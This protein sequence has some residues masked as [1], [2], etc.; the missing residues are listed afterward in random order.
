MQSV[1]KLDIERFMGK[2]YVIS[3]IP[4]FVEK[5]CKNAYD[6]YSLNNDGTIDIQY[7]ADKDGEP[8]RISQKGIAGR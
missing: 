1:K 3:S 5:G 7:Y 8:F 6:I 4:T 2:W